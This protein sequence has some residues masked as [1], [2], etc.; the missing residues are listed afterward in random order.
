MYQSEHSS[1]IGGIGNV[2]CSSSNYSTIIGGNGNYMSGAVGSAIVGGKNINLYSDCVVAVPML[3]TI[4]LTQDDISNNL[5]VFNSVANDLHFRPLSTILNGVSGTFSISGA[6]ISTTNGLVMSVSE[7]INIFKSVIDGATS[8]TNVN[9][10]SSSQLI[11][12]GTFKVGDVLVIA[13]RARKVGANGNITIRMYVNTTSSLSGAT[14]V[15]TYQATALA[16]P[17]QRILV[18]KTTTNTEVMPSGTSLLSDFSS[19]STVALTSLNI[20]WTI[21]QFVIFAVQDANQADDSRIS[22]YTIEKL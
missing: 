2:M 18:I 8:S 15:G 3:R 1:I 5:A 4:N 21:N 6:T 12:G 14:L 11:P 10:L 9:T 19:P 13:T 20:D 7:N 17:M 22:Y 16:I